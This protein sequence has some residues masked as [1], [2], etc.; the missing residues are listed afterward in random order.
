VDLL[1]FTAICI[2]VDLVLFN[3]IK[4][5]EVPIIFLFG[6][7]KLMLCGVVP[8]EID[9][10]S[11]ISAKGNDCYLVPSYLDSLLNRYWYLVFRFNSMSNTTVI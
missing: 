9:R 4:I 3:G 6:E 7:E 11:I 10:V 5:V 2:G 1:A 8:V